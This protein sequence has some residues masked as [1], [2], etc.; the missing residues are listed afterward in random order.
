MTLLFV[1]TVL[2]LLEVHHRLP[3]D[4]AHDRKKAQRRGITVEQFRNEELKEIEDYFLPYT[5]F[6][7]RRNLEEECQ[8]L[9]LWQQE[10]TA[11]G[12]ARA[13]GR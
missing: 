6:F 3:L 4:R 5:R 8:K 2:Y 12:G 9:T 7:A 11:I 13:I 10:D 1:P